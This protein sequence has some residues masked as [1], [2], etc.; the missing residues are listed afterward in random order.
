MS[1]GELVGE[2]GNGGQKG[3]AGVEGLRLE[4]IWIPE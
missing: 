1:A 2:A 3:Q 4:D